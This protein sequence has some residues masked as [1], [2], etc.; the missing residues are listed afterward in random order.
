[1]TFARCVWPRSTARKDGGRL[2]EALGSDRTGRFAF[3]PAGL[4]PVDIVCITKSETAGKYPHVDFSDCRRPLMEF[5]ASA[6]T[7]NPEPSFAPKTAI[8]DPR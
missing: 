8:S 5:W 3:L 4:V 1:M 6:P 2:F 7:G